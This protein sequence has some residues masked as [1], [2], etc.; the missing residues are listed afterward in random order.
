ME[1]GV[2]VTGGLQMGRL[3]WVAGKTNPSMIG[4]EFVKMVEL[5]E[6]VRAA[7]KAREE[8]HEV[9]DFMIRRMTS[10]GRTTYSVEELP[11]RRGW[12]S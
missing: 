2:D 5:D 10:G 4:S 8:R 11:V 12:L 3:C 7:I 1:S 6:K 9:V